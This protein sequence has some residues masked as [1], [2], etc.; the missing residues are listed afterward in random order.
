MTNIIDKII[1]IPIV[2][3]EDYIMCVNKRLEIKM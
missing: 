3:P 1:I 2:P